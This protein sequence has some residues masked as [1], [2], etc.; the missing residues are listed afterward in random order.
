MADEQE[1]DQKTEKPTPRRLEEARQK[2]SLPLSRDV[3]ATVVLGAL[4]LLFFVL[5]G[6]LAT[7]IAEA[8][9]PL[10]ESPD[11]VEFGTSGDLDTVI[12]DLLIRIGWATAPILLLLVLAAVLG[13]VIQNGLVVSPERLHWK[14]ERISPL[15]GLKRLFSLNNLVELAKGCLKIVVIVVAGAL[16][17]GPS[18]GSLDVMPW[19]DPTA[20]AGLVGGASLK[21]LAYISIAMLVIAVA[22]AGWQRFHWWRGLH[23]TRTELREEHRQMEGSPEIK[24]R[25][26]MLRRERARK[27]MMAAVPQATVVITN[28]T[29]FAVALVYDR[30]TMRA[31]R[32]VA[33]GQDLVAQRIRKLAEESGVPVVENKP[34]ARALHE[35]VE[36]DADVPPEHYR[37]VAE[38]ISYVLSLRRVRA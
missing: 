28:P 6:A 4:T 17:L 13:H 2:G 35:A 38:V 12:S 11:T 16:A 3:T 30:L 1:K 25:I 9:R 31:P 18:L 34:L 5:G 7:D 37:A 15:A 27:R 8:M 14:L 20:I 10:L 23:M 29:H 24:A 36:I 33:K 21:L 26:K 22:D 32:C 19:V